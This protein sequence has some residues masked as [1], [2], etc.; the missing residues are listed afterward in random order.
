MRIE[1]YSQNWVETNASKVE[2]QDRSD[3]ISRSKTATEGKPCNDACKISASAMD[4][5]EANHARI[6]EI[7]AQIASGTYK[8]NADNIADAMLRSL[9]R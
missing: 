9:A 2:Q 3:G 1:G 4:S 7:R 8:L 6:E 5:T